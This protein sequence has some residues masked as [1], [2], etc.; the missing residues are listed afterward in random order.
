M[1]A[2]F[3]IPCVIS[4]GVGRDNRG[5]NY[6]YL[7]QDTPELSSSSI[8]DDLSRVLGLPYPH[9]A[10]RDAPRNV[11]RNLHVAAVIP[12]TIVVELGKVDDRWKLDPLGEHT[13][14]GSESAEEGLHYNPR[15]TGVSLSLS[16]YRP[17]RPP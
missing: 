14:P 12:S 4:E 13:W 7:C 6:T 17:H 2:P 11:L 16:D 15:N 9:L 1:Y 8:L 10:Q 5:F 3:T